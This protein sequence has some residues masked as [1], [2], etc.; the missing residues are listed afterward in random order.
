M[1]HSTPSF[2]VAGGACVIA[3]LYI[4]EA[5][6]SEYLSCIENGAVWAKLTIM[7][8][9]IVSAHQDDHNT[10]R[11]LKSIMNSIRRCL[12]RQMS[13]IFHP[14]FFELLLGLERT[15][16]QVEGVNIYKKFGSVISGRFDFSHPN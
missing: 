11:S 4:A 1:V 15:N 16:C 13:N 14:S 8:L 6:L 3:L 12:D 5:V 2:Q 9:C 7:R 10:V